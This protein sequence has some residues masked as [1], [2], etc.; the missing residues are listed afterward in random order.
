ME[1]LGISKLPRWLQRGS[2]ELY[3]ETSEG[4]DSCFK[5]DLTEGALTNGCWI[6]LHPWLRKTTRLQHAEVAAHADC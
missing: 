6:L 2:R 5:S 1:E 3:E 4:C